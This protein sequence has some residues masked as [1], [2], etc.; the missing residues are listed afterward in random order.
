MAFELYHSHA[1]KERPLEIPALGLKLSVR[2]PPEVSRGAITI[3]EQ[4]N[5]PGFGPPLHRHNEAEI[6]QVLEG[7]YLYEVNGR[8]F[9]GKVGDLIT[10]PA[11]SAHA[12]VNAGERPARQMIFMLPGLDAVRFFSELAVVMADGRP[13]REELNA[14]GAPWGVEFLGA[15][16]RAT[17]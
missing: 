12:F 13:S 14:F 5:A 15:P 6:F 17:L 1:G 11:G 16:I 4:V 8:R 10:A 2:L 9:Y 3:M 7:V